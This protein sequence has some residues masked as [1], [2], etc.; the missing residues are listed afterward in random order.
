[1]NQH[2]NQ[3]VEKY[4]KRLAQLQSERDAWQQHARSLARKVAEAKKEAASAGESAEDLEEPPLLPPEPEPYTPGQSLLSLEWPSI[5]SDLCKALLERGKTAG[6]L[7]DPTEVQKGP[8]LGSGAFGTTY[9]ATWRGADVA[10]KC[11]R[12][13]N[14]DELN[15]FLQEVE[16][17][18]QVWCTPCCVQQP[19]C[20]G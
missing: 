11:V 4:V 12:I 8:V 7:I 13:S 14:A 16:T 10:V 6:W 1:V 9:R 20:A 19:C 18:S 15:S 2:L 3:E 17:L 5:N